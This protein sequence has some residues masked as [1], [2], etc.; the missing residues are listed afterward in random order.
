MIV[1]GQDPSS[2]NGASAGGDQVFFEKPI[3]DLNPSTNPAP[4]KGLIIIAAAAVQYVAAKDAAWVAGIAGQTKCLTAVGDTDPNTRTN[5]GGT[6][7]VPYQ[8]T[9]GTV[10]VSLFKGD[11]GTCTGTA[12]IGPASVDATDGSRTLVLAYGP[13]ATHFKLLAL[14]VAS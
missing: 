7:L 1:M 6:S 3:T 11:P 8:V 10:S 5:I 2:G 12:D 14:P 13:D 9:P 4:G